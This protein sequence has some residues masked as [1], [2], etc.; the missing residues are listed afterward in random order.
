MLRLRLLKMGVMLMNYKLIWNYSDN[1]TVEIINLLSN[2]TLYSG[3]TDHIPNLLEFKSYVISKITLENYDE[4]L[5]EYDL[6]WDTRD[7][8]E[9]DQCYDTNYNMRGENFGIK[10]EYSKGCF[11]EDLTIH[12]DSNESLQDFIT[13]LNLHINAFVFGSKG[14]GEMDYES[15]TDEDVDVWL[16]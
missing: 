8:W 5:D 13:K 12:A 4:F 7:S 11:G 15:Y 6:D 9:C 1:E 14:I 10:Y 2:E 16:I 3:S